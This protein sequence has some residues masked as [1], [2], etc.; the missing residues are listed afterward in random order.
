MLY[1]LYLFLEIIIFDSTTFP[2]DKN[3]GST[4]LCFFVERNEK[5]GL[6]GQY[7]MEIDF[8]K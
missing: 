8:N 3:G 5:V 2:C 1:S 6:F 4:A 7:L